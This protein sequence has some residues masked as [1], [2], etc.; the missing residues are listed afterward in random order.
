MPP[1]PIPRGELSDAVLTALRRPAHALAAPAPVAPADALRD[2]DLQLALYVMYELH[3]RGLDGVD[4]GWEWEPSLLALRREV[5][6]VFTE[7]LFALAGE[8]ER[9]DVVPEEM[10]VALRAIAEADDGPS[11][12]TYLERRGTLDQVLE[13]V[14][15]RSAYQLKEADP[16][17]WAI[18]R[19]TG[20]AKAAIVEIEADEFGGGRAD[21]I[22]AR[23]FA[24]AMDE[25]GL[26][27][28][29]GAYVDRIPALTLATVNLMSMLGLHRRWRGAIVGHLALFEMTSSL[30]NRRYGNALR[31][32]GFGERATAFFDEHVEADAVHEAIAAVDLAGGFVRAEPALTGDVL[33]G[34]RALAAIEAEWARSLLAA[35]DA[36]RPS[37]LAP[38]GEAA[39]A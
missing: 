37:L 14:V 10:D 22:H 3:Y 25:L 30:P 21:R 29:Y 38:L 23:L 6:R 9:E 27:P 32:L 1:V 12:S 13:F 39:P 31:R 36:G 33:W 17:A 20:Q 35:W 18:P 5:E 26:D 28:S 34:A 11:L 15:H 8:P 7:A 16:H 2:E 4:E 24:D 19:L